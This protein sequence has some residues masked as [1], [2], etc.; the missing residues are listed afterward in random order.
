MSKKTLN[1]ANLTALGADRLAELLMEVSTGSADIKRRLRMELSHN[2]GAS[3]LAH[4]VRKRLAAIRK[5]KARVSWRK[6]KSLVADLNTCI[7]ITDASRLQ[8]LFA[9]N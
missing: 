4:D 6:R 7:T 1:A 8:I 2:L 3:E 5:S 9:V